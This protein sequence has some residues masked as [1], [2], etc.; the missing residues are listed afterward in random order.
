M[1]IDISIWATDTYF[2]NVQ[3]DFFYSA[4]TVIESI[5]SG[6]EFAQQNY[7]CDIKSYLHPFLLILNQ[8]FFIVLRQLKCY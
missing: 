8:I 2:A 1:V 6:G 7:R 3:L 5:C 4:N